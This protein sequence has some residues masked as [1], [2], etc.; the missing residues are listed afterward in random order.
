MVTWLD[1]K[2]AMERLGVHEGDSLIVHSSFK[3]LGEVE[4]G[5]ESVM[6]GLFAALGE[7]GTLIFPT[8]CQNDWLNVYK[9]WHLDA[10]SDVGYLTNYFRK[11]PGALRSNQATHSVAAIGKHAAYITATHGESGLRHGIYGETP[12]AADSPWEKMYE[13]NTKVLIIGRDLRP[14]TMR[15]LAEYRFMQEWQDKAK[16]SPRYQELIDRVWCY[17]RWNERGV[18][19]HLDSLYIGEL[20][21]AEGKLHKTTCGNAELTV[22]PSREFVDR[23]IDCMNKRDRKAFWEDGNNN[24]VPQDTLDW[25]QEVESL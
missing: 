12:F 23:A 6:R 14:C 17:E 18:W 22:V 4:N 13:L 16:K 15:H 24:W 9:N 1:V 3:S 25:L 7:E 5:A 19:W 10:P 8:L 2:Q 11:L 21:A 20:L